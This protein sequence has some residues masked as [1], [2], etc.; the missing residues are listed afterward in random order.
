MKDASP[1][2]IQNYI[3]WR[4]IQH[5]ALFLPDAG[6]APLYQF[7]ANLTGMSEHNP[8]E[9]WHECVLYTT[10][11]LPMPTGAIY[12]ASY[13]AGA[14]VL[15]KMKD[16]AEALRSSFIE[17]LR[18]VD[19]MD[20]QT[21]NE[22][23]AKAYK[24]TYR[25]AH[26]DYFNNATFM[27]LYWAHIELTKKSPPLQTAIQMKVQLWEEDASKLRDPVD[28]NWWYQSPAQVEAYYAPSLHQMS[29]YLCFS[30]GSLRHYPATIGTLTPWTQD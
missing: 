4:I 8:L 7:K 12:V 24:L 27:E 16:M 9:R 3:I 2:T 20:E 29:E 6:K 5:Y 1:R 10:R 28:V 15:E 21:K 13:F 18:E 22:A 19:W 11:V 23:L 26:P 30:L 17:E 25:I 14:P